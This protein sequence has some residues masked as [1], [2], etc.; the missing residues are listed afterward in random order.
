MSYLI[1]DT[2]SFVV[3][4]TIHCLLPPKNER[5]GGGGLL[6]SDLAL[7]LRGFCGWYFVI[8]CLAAVFAAFA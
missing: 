2:D 4:I 8:R 3:K 5:L 7:L 1:F 6:T